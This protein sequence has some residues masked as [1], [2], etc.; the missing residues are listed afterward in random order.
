VCPSIETLEDETVHE[1]DEEAI[2][3][4]EPPAKKRKHSKR[5]LTSS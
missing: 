4:L 5:R 1:E 3:A 2:P